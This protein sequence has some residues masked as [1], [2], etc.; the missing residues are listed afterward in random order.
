MEN[1]NRSIGTSPGLEAEREFVKCLQELEYKI[2]TDELLD[3]HLKLDGVITA[4]PMSGSA[5]FYPTPIAMQ[6]TTRIK[7]WEK[8]AGCV[9]VARNIASRLAYIELCGYD[10]TSEMVNAADAA[11]RSMFY[12]QATPQIALVEIRNN[13][14]SIADLDALLI[15]YQTWLKTIIPGQLTGEIT[16][17][18]TEKRWGFLT[19]LARGPNGIVEEVQFYF[20]I[21]SVDITLSQKLDG[22]DGNISIQVTF[23]DGGVRASG[24]R[25]RKSAIN[26]KFA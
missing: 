25:K 24:E 15:Q 16:V 22:L 2:V 19:A 18:K 8:R 23:E 6:V 9:Q 26:V 20:H 21:S 17:W 7:D 11:L 1:G 4:P 5:F 3:Q 14:Y 10:I 12:C 13:N